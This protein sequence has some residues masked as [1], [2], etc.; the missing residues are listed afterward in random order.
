MITDANPKYVKNFLKK[1][2]DYLEI[3]TFN[4]KIENFP[5][6]TITDTY[7]FTDRRENSRINSGRRQ[8]DLLNYF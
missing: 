3:Y 6:D 1:S 8:I 7:R 4:L 5:I 2:A